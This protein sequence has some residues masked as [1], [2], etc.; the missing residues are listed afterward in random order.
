MIPI[1]R[2]SQRLPG[3]ASDTMCRTHLSAD[4]TSVHLIHHIAERSKFVFSVIAVYAIIDGDEAYILFRKKGIRII[5]DAEIISTEAGHILND[6]RRYIAHFY[7]LKHLLKR[8]TV[9]ICA[10]IAIIYVNTVFDTR[11][12]PN[13]Q[14]L[15]AVSLR[16]KPSFLCPF[17][18]FQRLCPREFEPL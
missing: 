7:I 9:E 8:R 3:I 2:L 12:I 10:G 14:G 17:S 6:D 4:V 15:S 11:K 16:R 18:V 5:A 1:G 13:K